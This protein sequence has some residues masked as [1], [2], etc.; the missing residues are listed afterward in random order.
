MSISS[1]T[2]GIL[3][4]VNGKMGDAGYFLNNGTAPP[5][6]E[7]LYGIKTPTATAGTSLNPNLG[8]SSALGTSMLGTGLDSSLTSS[9]G[10][11]LT[12]AIDPNA[13]AAAGID[14]NSLQTLLTSLVGLL[15]PQQKPAVSGIGALAQ[16]LNMQQFGAVR[17]LEPPAVKSKPGDLTP[18]GSSS[19]E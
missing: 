13:A 8:L 4:I 2:L 19:D 12:A 1:G 7:A 10:A 18:F 11:S 9:L 3:G 16:K 6:K 14:V 15:V 17:P 5:G